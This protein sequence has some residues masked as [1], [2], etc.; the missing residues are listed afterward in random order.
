MALAKFAEDIQEAIYENL[1]M[2]EQDFYE[3]FWGLEPDVEPD[4]EKERD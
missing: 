1:A 3:R 4:S 2:R